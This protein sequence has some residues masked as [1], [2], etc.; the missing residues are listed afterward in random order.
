M[1][2]LVDLRDNGIAFDA[3]LFQEAR[4]LVLIFAAAVRTARANALKR[5]KHKG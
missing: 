2:H 5:K 3:G 1:D 4:E